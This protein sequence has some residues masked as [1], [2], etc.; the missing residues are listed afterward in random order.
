MHRN[1][2]M[3]A[4]ASAHPHEFLIR[5]LLLFKYQAMLAIV[6]EERT[7]LKKAKRTLERAI[8]CKDEDVHPIARHT[9]PKPLPD[10]S[11]SFDLVNK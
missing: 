10:I 6:S 4:A 9:N 11:E 2:Y 8:L 1:D 7:Q 5:S 3:H